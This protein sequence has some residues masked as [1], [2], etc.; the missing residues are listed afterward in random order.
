MLFVIGIPL[1]CW[2]DVADAQVDK[3]PDTVP[4]I[5][6]VDIPDDNF[7]TPVRWNLSLAEGTYHNRQ[8][9]VAKLQN[10]I[11]RLSHANLLW[12]T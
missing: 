7:Q 3:V 1:S 8:G 5:E 11:Y 12:V 4:D 6:A 2:I 9:Q 10:R